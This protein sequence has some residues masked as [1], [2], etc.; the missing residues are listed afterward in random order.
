MPVLATYTFVGILCLPGAD[1]TGY[2]CLAHG[3]GAQPDY[4]IWQGTSTFGA[5]VSVVTRGAAAIWCRKEGG[6]SVPG[7]VVAQVVHSIIR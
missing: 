3:L 7:E 2:A 4:A 1:A 6:V 5:A